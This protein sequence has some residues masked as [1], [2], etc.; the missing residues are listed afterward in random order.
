M[1]RAGSS[2]RARSFVTAH[3]HGYISAA[4]GAVLQY[5]ADWGGPAGHHEFLA[6]QAFH[7]E[8]QAAIAGSV[9][10][11]D[12]LRDDPFDFQGAGMIVESPPA[13]DLVIA[14][15]QRR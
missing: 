3:N 11:V 12:P 10:R 7:F 1:T 9:G 14:E 2:L 15:M 4:R 8:P 6:V 13:S 5:T